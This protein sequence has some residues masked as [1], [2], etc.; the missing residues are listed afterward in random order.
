MLL[1]LQP[2]LW[3]LF[4]KVLEQ[5]IEGALWSQLMVS[6]PPE[7]GPSPLPWRFLKWAELCKSEAQMGHRN[8]GDEVAYMNR[9]LCF[10]FGR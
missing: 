6:T 9:W 3:S 10:P 1:I 5:P 7:E 2:F 8:S 4:L